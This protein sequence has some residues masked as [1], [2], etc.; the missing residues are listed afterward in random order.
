MAS[1]QDLMAQD[2][3]PLPI[4]KG[5]GFS[6]YLRKH[7]RPDNRLPYS[8]E[9]HEA[10]RG[11]LLD[12]SLRLVIHKGSQIGV[13]LGLIGLSFFYIDTRKL[14]GI[15]FLPTDKLA[16]E[17]GSTRVNRVID[18]N[19]YYRPI[20]TELQRINKRKKDSMTI[21][22]I[23]DNYFYI[24]GLDTIRNALS[25]PA[26][27][28]VYDEVDDINKEHMT[29]SQDRIGHSKFGRIIRVGVG[30]N[31]GDGIDLAYSEKSDRHLWMHKC[32]G[33]GREQVLAD[34]FYEKEKK[35]AE[36]AC[37]AYRDS[38]GN[39]F[40]GCINCGKEIDRD[41]GRWVAE[42]PDVETRG[43]RI[44]QLDIS[45][46]SANSIMQ[47]W[48]DDK[49]DPRKRA[50]FNCSVLAKADAGPG[51][52]ITEDVLN[53]STGARTMIDRADYSFIGVDRGNT[54][55]LAIGIL[56]GDG[57]FEFIH[58]EKFPEE[59]IEDRFAD[60]WRRF[61]CQMAVI[62]ARPGTKAPADIANSYGREFVL[63]QMFK[64][65]VFEVKD[66]E[67]VVNSGEIYRSV[68][69]DK[70]I[71][72]DDYTDRFAKGKIIIPKK[73][74]GERG[75]IIEEMRKAHKLLQ[76]S[77]NPETGKFS[78]RSGREDHYAMAASFSLAAYLA[79]KTQTAIYTGAGISTAKFRL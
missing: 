56:V 43:Y 45:W 25:V 70:L 2:L 6:S 66:Y 74:M 52:R 11:P 54:C 57:D 8:F 4:E 13:S 63:F 16:A 60:L 12:K 18:L 48:L 38:D 5:I 21:K 30:R 61:N 69:M 46:I 68:S 62:D 35:D 33:C 49:D 64:G 31:P 1:L 32:E 77:Y 78:Y 51:Q 76:K 28:L 27:F 29:F 55:H 59:A 71:W 44:S 65:G 26:D 39:W 15:Y 47:R 41:K 10:L 14:D 53:A 24:K 36:G 75:K 37:N 9:G 17:F 42:R 40:F 58:F 34:E 20:I 79:W 67:P 19:D 7:I 3:N 22:R 73:E 23:R 72:L 50:W